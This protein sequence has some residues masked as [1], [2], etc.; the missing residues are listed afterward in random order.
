MEVH[1]HAHTARKKWT[2]YFWEFLM[3]F[4]AVFCGFLAEYQ[5]EHTIEHNKEKEYMTSMSEDLEQDTIEINRVITNIK[6]SLVKIDTLLTSLESSSAKTRNDLEL[7]YDIHYNYLGAEVAVLSQRTLSQL[8]NSGGLRLIRFK[9]VADDISLYDS[10]AQYLFAITKSYDDA[11]TEVMKYGTGIFDNRYVR[12]KL[13]DRPIDL[14]RND[15]QTL[16][17]YSNYLF[18]VRM[19]ANYYQI[20]LARQK[21]SAID[22]MTLI[23]KKYHLE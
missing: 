11:S 5:L 2:H 19:V 16:R 20:Y 10:K 17:Q 22:L 15:W 8:K 9:K 14:L 3:L 23:K 21:Q 18:V 4:L 7:M 1:H 13:K 12:N 6:E